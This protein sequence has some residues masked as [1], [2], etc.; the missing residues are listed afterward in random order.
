MLLIS[1]SLFLLIPTSFSESLVWSDEFDTLDD[2][3]WSHLVT[4]YPLDDFQYYRNNRANSWVSDGYLH[5]MPTLTAAEYGEDFLYSGKLDLT[6][7]NPD[8]PCNIWYQQDTLCYDEAGEDIVKP[9]QMAR[10]HT[11]N[12]FTFRYG[13]VEVRARLPLANWIRPAIWMLSNNNSYG[14]FPAS[15]EFDLMESSG[16]RDYHC[17]KTSRGVDTVQTNLHMGY[18]G[19][20][21]HWS[22][23]TLNTN[24][25]QNYADHFHIYEL[26]W[27]ENFAAY[28]IDGEEIYR[29]TAPGPPGGLYDYAG[30]DGDNIWASGGPMAPF[31]KDFYFVL[32]AASGGWPFYDYCTP[33]APWSKDSP[34][35][36]REFWE[37]RE[38]WFHTWS[39]PFS[40]DYIRLYQ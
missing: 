31:D 23:Y 40:I 14:G 13:R 28:S 5:M 18:P 30:F 9:I 21:E 39:Q 37:S 34:Q 7:E 4:T 11:K 17:G 32:S 27:N 19:S 22:N 3:I 25:T 35:K 1:F 15:G 36:R 29:L 24:T 8:H 38:S 6:T 16:N 2:E 20:S 12:K 10:L 26:E 33:P